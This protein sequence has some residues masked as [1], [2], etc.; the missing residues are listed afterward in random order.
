MIIYGPEKKSFTFKTTE[1]S[2]FLLH[3]IKEFGFSDKINSNLESI[4]DET[5]KKQGKCSKE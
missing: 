5:R 4:N 3:Y 1:G 2:S